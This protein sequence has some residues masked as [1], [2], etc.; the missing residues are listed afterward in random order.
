MTGLLEEALRRA[1]SGRPHLS[2]GAAADAPWAM[3]A[4]IYLDQR[5]G[6]GANGACPM[7]E[8]FN[9]VRDKHP[10]LSVTDF[11]DR[12]R[13]LRDRHAL[14]L[15]PFAGEG[16]EIPEPELALLDGAALLYYVS[17]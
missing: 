3:D 7:P 17:R 5:H 13:R 11:H 16:S 6:A 9:A 12:L 15:L 8:L 10:Q 4:L 14:H 1:E 2:E